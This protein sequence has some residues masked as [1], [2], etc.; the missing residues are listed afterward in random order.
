MTPNI[1]FAFLLLTF[2][3]SIFLPFFN[4]VS[5][6]KLT[7]E[8]K[9]LKIHELEKISKILIALIC[10]SAVASQLSLIYSYI[11]SDYSVINVYQNSHHLKPLIYKISGSWGN[12]E[13]SMLLLITILCLYSV[14]FAFLSHI[15]TNIK[16][17]ILSCQ[18]LI[19]AAFSSFAAFSSNPFLKSA[20]TPK[21]GLGLNPVLQDIGLA[22]HPPMLYT[23]YIGFSLIFSFAIAGLLTE[24]INATLASHLKKWLLFAWGFLTLGIGLGSW[25]AYR[26]LGWG[27]YWF[28]DPVEN[29]SLMPWIAGAS[30]VHCVKLLEKK[31]LFKNW[32]AFL[33]ILSFILC[34]LGIFLTRS[35]I[36]TSVHSFAIDAKRG[37]FVIALITAIGGVGLLIFGHKSPKIKSDR[38]QFHLLSRIGIILVN[39]YFLILSLFIVVLGTTYPLLSQSLFDQFISIGPNYYNKL[40]TIL[41]IPFLAFL[42]ISLS[43][44]FLEKTN[45][46]KI[47]NLTNLLICALAATL[48]T[49]TSYYHQDAQNSQIIILFLALF[50]AITT[51]IHYG[52]F[53]LHSKSKLLSKHNFN[54]LPVTA[55]HFGFSLIICGVILTS[56]FGLTK[57]TNIKLGNSTIVGDYT[58]KFSKIDHTQGSNYIARQGFFTVTK[59][60]KPF[61]TLVPALRYYPISNQTTNEAA[62]KSTIFEDLYL[63]L[64]NKDE[65]NFYAIR[66]YTK[67][68]IYFIWLGCAM[69]FAA[70]M[71]SIVL[72]IKKT[73]HV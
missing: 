32:T 43:L 56:S 59:H 57:E 20:I 29:I 26:E 27:G 61:I 19:I 35:G 1:G 55:A 21:E 14:A 34:L 63:A 31:N 39:N 28:W 2:L 17:I 65:N 38:F 37:F 68:F 49:L 6:N 9:T 64:G 40:F 54:H 66:V 70:A 71:L 4:Y 16:L 50:S 23:G 46:E 11:K 30:L 3:T 22:L 15:Q 41:L 45:K 47:I 58:I 7:S 62:I 52:K 48:T 33:S 10:F 72:A 69:I 5:L 8:Q 73:K 53:I 13:G 60:E 25:W 36:L 67:P 44:N 51:L 24:K 12:H 42:A 18:S